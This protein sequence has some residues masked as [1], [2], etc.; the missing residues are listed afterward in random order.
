ME[1][2]L[3]L[4]SGHSRERACD[5]FGR[6]QLGFGPRGGGANGKQAERCHWYHKPA[7]HKRLRR[8]SRQRI[9]WSSFSPPPHEGGAPSPPIAREEPVSAT[10]SYSRP[11]FWARASISSPIR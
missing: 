3:R 6:S 8:S 10:F 11:N 1:D 2:P 9:D 5:S 7:Y 4:H